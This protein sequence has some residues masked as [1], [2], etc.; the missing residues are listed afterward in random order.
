MKKKKM[1]TLFLCLTM[2]VGMFTACAGNG[3]SKE[4]GQPSNGSTE[5][6]ESAESAESEEQ[7]SSE[8]TVDYS[9][10]ETFSYWLNATNISNDF[11]TDYTENPVINYLDE[12]FNVTLEFEH[13]VSG[14]EADALALMFS[15][16]E[17][18]DVVDVSSYTGSIN[19]L[20][21]DGVVIDIAEYLD[22]MPNLKG[23]LDSDEGFRKTM[24]N[25]VGKILTL[26]TYNTAPDLPWCGFVYRRDILEKMTDGK[27]AFPSGNENPTTLEDWEYMLPM[28]KQYFEESG[29]SDYAALILPSNGLIHYGDLQSGFGAYHSYYLDAKT[30]EIRYGAVED[31]FYNYLKKMNEWYEAGYIYRDFASR[32]TDMF[33]MPNTALTYSGAAGVFFGMFNTLEDQMSDPE[34]GLE[35]NVKPVAGALDTENGVEES[36]VISRSRPNYEAS[37]SPGPVIT[38][39][40]KNIP[41]LLSVLDYGYTE[42]GS[43]LL[44]FG[45]TKEQIPESDT[46][47]EAAGLQDGAYWFEG[48]N[49]VYNPVITEAGS[50]GALGIEQMNG[51]RIMACISPV[52]FIF[53]ETYTDTKKN[54]VN[55]WLYF[56]E[57]SEKTFLPCSLSYTAEDEA[58]I[59]SNNVSMLDYQNSMIPKFIMGT[60]S[61][62]EASWEA[63]KKQIYAYG[64]E[65][66]LSIHQDAYGRFQNR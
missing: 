59:K 39:K 4:S 64:L 32:T 55:A 44:W 43:M 48:D 29:M 63:F 45:M 56:Q 35:F 5:N 7:A 23:L 57:V 3:D 30:D 6:A 41:K 66:N 34:N 1:L 40:C 11:Y 58:L 10:N 61:L 27:V 9:E 16:G 47:Y 26:R 13:P 25:D 49:F 38:S 21:E 50:G 54:A 62:D 31:E 65:D 20:H 52:E 28:Y 14:A 46:V 42:E 33:F 51:I 18:T 8:G 15:T 2:V 60:E 36:Q 12:K 37:G 53:E 24:Y 17:Y 22:Y 19:E